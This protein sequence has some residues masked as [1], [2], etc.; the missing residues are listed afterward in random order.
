[1]LRSTNIAFSARVKR[2]AVTVTGTVSVRDANGNAASNAIVSATW[3]LPDRST[4]LQSAT[5]NSTGNASF[6][7]TSGRGTYTLTVTNITKAGYIF[8]QANSIL[9]GSITK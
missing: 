6:S 1:M 3:T 7:A 4:Q 5:T 8:D 2:S 9:R